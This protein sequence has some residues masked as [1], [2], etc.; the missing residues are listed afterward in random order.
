M[1]MGVN[2]HHSATFLLKCNKFK[3]FCVKAPS[4]FTVYGGAVVVMSGE[5]DHR[6]SYRGPPSSRS[7]LALAPAGICTDVMSH[8]LV[9]DEITHT[10]HMLDR[11]G[12]FL[13]HIYIGQ[14]PY[15]LSYDVNTHVV[16]VS[17][18]KDNM[19]YKYRYINRHLYLAG[20]SHYIPYK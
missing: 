17:S 5:G 3:Y 13:L 1:I 4:C 19:L 14:T 8:I 6:F 9:S 16:W 18:L 12:K 20:K 11:D 2:K 7:R 15:S 10:V